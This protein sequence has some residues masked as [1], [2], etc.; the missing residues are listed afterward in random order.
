MP[1]TGQDRQRKLRA[2]CRQQIGVKTV[3]VGRG[4]TATQQGHHIEQLLMRID[5]IQR[6]DHRALRALPL[7]QGGKQFHIEGIARPI[8][9]QLIH[10]ILIACRSRRRD[11]CHPLGQEWQRQLLVQTKH[12]LLLQ[13]ADNLQPLARHISQRISRINIHHRQAQAIQL[14]EIHR[15]PH[16]HLQPRDEALP[17]LHLEIGLQEAK[18]L[19]PNGSTYLSQ[20]LSTTGILLDKLQIAMPRG[21]VL[22]HIAHLR[23]HP[24]GVWES[25]LQGHVDALVQLHQR[26]CLVGR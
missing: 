22:T 9:H 17:R 14:M 1:D 7:H 6:C 24:I 8:V 21:T 20:E 15:D 3:Q 4:S 16:Q 19:R 5:P 26:E 23:P 2:V 12:A 18:G 10:E 13:L 11:Q 25:L